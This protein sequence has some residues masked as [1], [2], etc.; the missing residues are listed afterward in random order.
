MPLEVA[1]TRGKV[2]TWGV[3]LLPKRDGANYLRERAHLMA[4]SKRLPRATVHV[5]GNFFTRFE[6]RPR[7]RARRSRRAGTRARSPGREPPEPDPPGSAPGLSPGDGN[8][9]AL[10]AVL[11]ADPTLPDREGTRRRRSKRG[12]RRRPRSPGLGGGL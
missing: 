2:M 5:G 12:R 7:G 6:P 9:G 10:R 3:V 8:G 11:S 4:T 1:P